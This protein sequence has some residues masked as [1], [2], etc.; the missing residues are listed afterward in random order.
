MCNDTYAKNTKT[1]VSYKPDTD[2]YT[3]WGAVGLACTNLRMMA[4]AMYDAGPKLTQQTF[5]DALRK[6]PPDPIGGIGGA[7]VV[8]FIDK[9][10]TPTAAFESRASYPCTLPAPPEDTICLLP[11]TTKGR[12]IAP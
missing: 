3:K 4:R 6:L 10:T 2:G 8:V 7:P 9:K 1:G 5:V 11:V 12:T